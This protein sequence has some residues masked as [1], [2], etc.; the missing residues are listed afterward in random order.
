MATQFAVKGLS[1]LK[2]LFARVSEQV[3]K[4]PLRKGVSA[5]AKIV[6]GA[7]IAAAPVGEYPIR[8]RGSKRG[9]QAGTLKRAVI[10]KFAREKSS[11]TQATMIVTIRQGRP[12]SKK[13]LNASR[14]AYYGKFVERGHRIVPRSNRIGTYR[15]KALYRKSI[16]RRRRDAAGRVSARPFMGPAFAG[17]KDRALDAMVSTMT[18]ELKK[19]IG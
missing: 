6:K 11:A 14:D 7:V 2:A 17:A 4:T 9:H 1:E 12:G 19:V 8:G 5:G 16:T 3:G 15:G 13:K 18:E 10:T